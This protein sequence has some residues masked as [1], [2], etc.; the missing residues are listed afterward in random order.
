MNEEKRQGLLSKYSRTGDVTK[1][2]A[3]KNKYP[4]MKTDSFYMDVESDF[5]GYGGGTLWAYIW[6]PVNMQPEPVVSELSRYITVFGGDATDYRVLHGAAEVTIGTNKDDMEVFKLSE[7]FGVYVEKGM[8][9]S[10]NITHLDDPKLPMFYSEVVVG[11]NAPPEENPLADDGD[12]MKRFIKSGEELNTK[13][14]DTENLKTVLTTTHH[15]FKGKELVRRTWMPIIKPHIMAKYSHTHTFSEYLVFMGS[16]PENI[17]DLGGVVEFT[18][19]ENAD[20]LETF[21]FDK[22]TQ[23]HLAKGVWHSPLVFKEVRDPSKPVILCEVSYATELVDGDKLDN[24]IEEN[25]WRILP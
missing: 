10:I 17:A 11:A 3:G 23:F 12:G 22:A 2:A 5:G 16:D 9:Y 21:R 20:E 25:D 6:E 8:L 19:G 24:S 15:M 7:S 1:I 13:Y 18:I 14:P 4:Q